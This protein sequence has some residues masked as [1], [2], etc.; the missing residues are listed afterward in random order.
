M[1]S[2][3]PSARSSASKRPTGASIIK[4]VTDLILRATELAEAEGRALKRHAISLG[5]AFAFALGAIMVGIGAIVALLA[6]L[7]MV[8]STQLGDAGAALAVGI[9]GLLIA[10]GLLWL[11]SKTVNPTK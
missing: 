9:L 11:A 1:V 10:G 2:A 3:S 7:F 8:L 6:A 5:L 4:I